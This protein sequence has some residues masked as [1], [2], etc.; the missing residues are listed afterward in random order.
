GDG[1][2]E[3]APRRQDGF[4]QGG[5]AGEGAAQRVD[6][7]VAARD[8]GIAM[9]IA[10]RRATLADAA[11]L[12]SL[13]AEVQAIH[14]AALPGWFTPTAPQAFPPGAAASLLGNPYNLVLVAQI[15]AEPVGYVYASMAHH[16]E[17][18]WRYAY[19][20]IYINQ[21][22]VRAAHRRRGVGAALIAA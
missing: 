13:N 3:A 21:I 14:A 20:M 9:P 4:R 11:L 22:G 6:A 15:G 1:R 12:S 19:D 5:R 2:A 10:V 8:G 18:P 16:A 17:T 7:R